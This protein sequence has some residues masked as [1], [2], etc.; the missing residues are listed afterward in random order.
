MQLL[1][2]LKDLTTKLIID[3]NEF[4]SLEKDLHRYKTLSEFSRPIQ[5]GYSLR[6]A[7]YELIYIC[8]ITLSMFLKFG[9]FWIDLSNNEINK[10]I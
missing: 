3:L 2:R 7:Y 6:E 4:L 5:V 1:I 10:G 8:N 9:T